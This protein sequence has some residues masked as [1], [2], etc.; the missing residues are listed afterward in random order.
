MT[1]WNFYF[2]GILHGKIKEEGDALSLEMLDMET[3]E[4][5]EK[6]AF[7]EE[8]DAFFCRIMQ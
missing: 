1:Q 2:S 7:T 5:A 6:S 3:G 4:W 8:E